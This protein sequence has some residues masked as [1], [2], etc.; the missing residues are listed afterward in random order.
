[1]TACCWFSVVT[2]F[3]CNCNKAQWPLYWHMWCLLTS[4]ICTFRC[5][6]SKTKQDR[7]IVVTMEQYIEVGTADYVAAFISS[8]TLP[9]DYCGFKFLQCSNT[10]TAWVSTWLQTTAAVIEHDRRH[11]TTVDNCWQHSATVVTCCQQSS[12][13]VLT[14]VV[15]TIGGPACFRTGSYL[16]A[17]PTVV[18]QLLLFFSLSG[19]RYIGDGG[20]D[21]S[22]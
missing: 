19:Y 3:Y 16:P 14:P 2:A 9:E 1:M 11:T 20:I 18:W 15:R 10:N 7:P 5:H 8:Q 12:S 6:I 13:V 21:R 22:P 4:V 17:R